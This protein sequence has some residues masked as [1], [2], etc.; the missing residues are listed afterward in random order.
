M[1]ASQKKK[2]SIDKEK[3]SAVFLRY[4]KAEAGKVDWRATETVPEDFPAI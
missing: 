4:K 2:Q 3:P 1:T